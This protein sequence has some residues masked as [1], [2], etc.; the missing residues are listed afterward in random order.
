MKPLADA[1][2]HV[3]AAMAPLPTVAV[4]LAEALGLCTA[5]PVTAAHDVPPFA[6]S[7]MDGFAVRASDT[8]DAPVRLDVLEDVP[9]GSVPTL[10]VGPGR[11]TR[12]MTGAPMPDGADAVVIV[13]ETTSEGSTVRV[14]APVAPGDS[15]RAAGSDVA[16]GATVL[17]AGVRLGP[18]HLGLLAA[19]GA[20]APMVRRRPVVAVLSTGDEVRPADAPALEPGAIRDANRPLLG[21][22]AAG[23]GAGVLDLGIVGDDAAALRSALE[24]AAG[25]ADVVLTSGGVSMGDYDLVKQ[26][27]G[28]LG[29]VE[30]WRVAMQPAKPFA[31]GFLG[32][33]PLFG[34]PGNP[35][36]AMVSFEQFVRPAL[37][38][39]M[40]ARRLFRPRVPGVLEH[41]V[42]TDPAKTVFLRASARHDGSAW[43]V[44][45]SGGQSSHV[46]GALAAA[47]AFA[48]VPVGTARLEA[49][50]PV[51][52]EM[53]HWP[54]SRTAEEVLGWTD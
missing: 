52:L 37:L 35:V 3:L 14:G 53:F 50:D 17:E 48:V 39:R 38:R 24:R 44:A 7:A 15:V 8:A 49:G 46:L 47:D 41:A 22:L 12:I 27:L 31:F 33:T 45:L 4:P 30:F 23:V 21:A 28:E 5:A 25:E 36:S 13:E 9:A 19:V 20:S 54:E 10:P 51:M 16:A 2:R 34:L 1:Q 43:R 29:S 32:G 11:A 42:E 40:G 6:N 26:V 18:A